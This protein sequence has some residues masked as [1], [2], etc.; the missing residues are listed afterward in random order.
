MTSTA[1]SLIISSIVTSA[2]NEISLL[3]AIV[4]VYGNCHPKFHSLSRSH[5]PSDPAPRAR[6]RLRPLRAP[7]AYIQALCHARSALAPSDRRELGA[8][9]ADLRLRALRL[10]R[11]AHLGRLAA[12]MQRTHTP[13]LLRREP[14]CAGQRAVPEAS[15]G[16]R[17]SVRCSCT[18]R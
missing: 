13:D 3:D 7:R 16:G 2:K 17:C 15:P 12:R 11:R 6:L 8:L 5:Q 4:V 10:D 14:A 9:C 18:A 1:F